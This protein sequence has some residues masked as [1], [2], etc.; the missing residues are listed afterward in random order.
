MKLID[1]R[2]S[3]YDQLTNYILRVV[4]I[5]KHATYNRRDNNGHGN[6]SRNNVY[7]EIIATI[8]LM[9]II[10][11]ISNNTVTTIILAKKIQYSL[12]ICDLLCDRIISNNWLTISANTAMKNHSYKQNEN[13][14]QQRNM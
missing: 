12:Y 13:A 14:K 7:K 10:K 5:R 4:M 9:A 11:I 8:I 3:R 1:E 2:R 6:N